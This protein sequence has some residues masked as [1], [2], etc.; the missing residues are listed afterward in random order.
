MRTPTRSTSTT[1]TAGSNPASHSVALAVRGRSGSVPWLWYSDL[2]YAYVPGVL[3][4]RF[5]A[6][7]EDRFTAS[8]ACPAVSCE[9]GDKWAA[10]EEY[11]TQLPV[12]ERLWQLRD[13]LAR[14]GESYWTLDPR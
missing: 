4:A 10:F 1:P 12:M 7:H 11:A 13:R 9:F 6:L 3:A 2:P 8:P 14:G 5:R